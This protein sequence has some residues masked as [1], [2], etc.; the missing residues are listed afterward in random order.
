MRRREVLTFSVKKLAKYEKHHFHSD[1]YAFTDISAFTID[2]SAY[3]QLAG[4]GAYDQSAKYSPEMLIEL[5]A[6]AKQ[7]GHAKA[8]ELGG[9]PSRPT[10][11]QGGCKQGTNLI[12]TKPDRRAGRGLAVAGTDSGFMQP[13]QPALW[14]R[15]LSLVQPRLGRDLRRVQT[16]GTTYA[17]PKPK[18]LNPKP[19]TR[20]R[21]DHSR[22]AP[23]QYL[24]TLPWPHYPCMCVKI[25][26]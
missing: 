14:V 16:R 23:S 12:K 7:R 17:S 20:K 9:R 5:V 19:K 22:S 4:K 11:A 13:W 8:R 18:T 2:S 26:P 6:Y 24:E 10:S 15:L 21:H 3:P 1:F 25:E